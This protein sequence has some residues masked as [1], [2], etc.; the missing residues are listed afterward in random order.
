MMDP[1]KV[2]HVQARFIHGGGD[3]NTLF[4]VNGLDPDR[5]R[6]DLAVGRESDQEMLSRVAPHVRVILIPELVRRI[7]PKHDI[8]TLIRLRRLIA[9]QRYHIVHTHMAKGGMLGRLAA[10][11]ARVPVIIHTIDGQSFHPHL[12]PWRFPMFKNM[13]RVAATFTDAFIVVGE[14]L[15]DWYQRAGVGTPAQ[16]HLIHSGMHLEDF[17]AAARNRDRLE[18]RIRAS[19]GVPAGVPLVGKVARH[20]EGKG[21][22]YFLDLAEQ[23]L[24]HHPEV[25]FVALGDGELLDWFQD[26]VCRRGLEGRVIAAG[27]RKDIAEV[28]ACLD[29]VVL[30]SLWEGLPRVLVQASAA[31][32]PVVTFDVGGAR[33]AIRDGESGHVVPSKDISAMARRVVF[34]LEA[35]EMARRMGALGQRH[36]DVRWSTDLVVSRVAGVYEEMLARGGVREDG[37]CGPT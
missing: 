11:L 2:L 1:I 15:R 30:T 18:P 34:L 33:E 20:T 24:R 10:R 36:V 22:N 12:D 3:E 4:T 21:Y 5:Y 31:G 37:S 23:V 7:S 14:E 28:L 8:A 35:P 16:Y 19:L 27:F 9:L 6:L 13:E 25:R 29:V 26:E 17:H 32:V